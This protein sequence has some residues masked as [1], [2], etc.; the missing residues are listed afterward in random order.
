MQI[1]PPK[2]V[3]KGLYLSLFPVP[4]TT[5][6]QDAKVP[7]TNGNTERLQRARAKIPVS[8][9]T[10][11]HSKGSPCVALATPRAQKH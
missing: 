6:R 4:A 10:E 8:N 2:T 1:W 7:A 3:V 9:G 11:E 5:A